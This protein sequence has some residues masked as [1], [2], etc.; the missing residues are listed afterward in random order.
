MAD[1]A[2]GPD[3]RGFFLGLT[4]GPLQVVSEVPI[5]RREHQSG[6]SDVAYLV[7]KWPSWLHCSWS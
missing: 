1:L 3:T 7:S 4:Y 5:L 2:D 6:V